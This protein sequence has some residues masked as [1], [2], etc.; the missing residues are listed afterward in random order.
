MDEFLII[1]A[2]FGLA[3]LGTLA[4]GVFAAVALEPKKDKKRR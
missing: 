3:W 2:L 1:C 4:L